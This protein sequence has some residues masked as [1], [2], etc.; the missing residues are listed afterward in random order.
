M[1][2]K[3]WI[4][5]SSTSFNTN[6]N[7]SD[8]AAPANND[9]I[10]FNH[11]GTANCTTN[12]GSTLTGITAYIDMSYTGQIGSISSSG[13]PTYLTF[14]GGTI[15]IGRSTTQGTGTGPTLC[16]IGNTGTT[17]MTINVYDSSSTGASTYFPPI[18]IDGGTNISLNHYGGN[19]GLCMFNASGSAE[20]ATFA[21]INVAVNGEAGVP[22]QLTIGSGVLVTTCT[23]NGGTIYDRSDV[24]VTTMLINGQA[25]VIVEGTASHSTIEAADGATINYNGNGTITTFNLRGGTLDLSGDTRAKT[26]T[27]LNAYDGSTLNVDNGEAGSVTFTNPINYPDGMDGVTIITPPGVKG[28][29][30]N[31]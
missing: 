9:T 30:T 25:T 27:T 17:A 21:T 14:D 22:A 8:G 12:L 16:M 28:T 6:A 3:T 20:A 31:I 13:V 11:L 15:Y 24:G 26:I 23:S 2:T 19:V 10:I 18:L 7:W 29:L 4:S 5:T 1:A